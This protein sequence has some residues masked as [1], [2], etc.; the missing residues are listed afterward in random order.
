MGGSVK[1]D[2]SE[3]EL[4]WD[5][6]ADAN[7]GVLGGIVGLVPYRGSGGGGDDTRGVEGDNDIEGV[8]A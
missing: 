2:A 4:E 3:L 1:A 6:D 5:A 8:D 7:A